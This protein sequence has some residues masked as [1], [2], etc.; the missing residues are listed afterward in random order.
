MKLEMRWK[1]AQCFNLID[2][3]D[4]LIGGGSKAIEGITTEKSTAF[5]WDHQGRDI[6]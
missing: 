4:V 5:H 1:L 6:A 3:R 2:L